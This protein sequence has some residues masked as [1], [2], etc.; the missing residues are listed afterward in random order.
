MTQGLVERLAAA[1]PGGEVLTDE[2]DR[3]FFATDVFRAGKMPLAV[4]APSTLA[5]LQEVVRLCGETRTP[6]AIRGGGASYTDG[7]TPGAPRGISLS[8]ARLNR[9]LEIDEEDRTVTVEPG[10]TW[11]ALDAALRPRGWRTPFFGPFSGLVSTVGGAVSQNAISHGTGAFGSAAE[12]LL[13]LEVVTGTGDLLATGS[14][15][16]AVADPFLRHYGPDLAGLFTGDCGALGVK[17]RLTFRLVRRQSAAAYASFR[18]ERFEA[19]HAAMHVISAEHPDDT[20]FAVDAEISAGQ[21]ARQARLENRLGILKSVLSDARGLK[22]GAGALMRLARA[23]LSDDL[24]VAPYAAHYVIEAASDAEAEA[25]LER[26]RAL[27]SAHGT[28]IPAAAANVTR[29]MPFQPLVS[30][31]G[32]HG[33]RWVPVHGLFP[34]SR[35]IGFHH[36]LKR[37]F[38]ERREIMETHGIRSGAMFMCVGPSA[39]LYEPTFVWPDART[40]YHARAMPAEWLARLPEL[41]ANPAAFEAVRALRAEVAELMDAHGA[42]HFQVGRF[43][44]YA[45]GRNPAALALLR[46][47]KTALD[48]HGILSPGALGL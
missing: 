37:L 8:T 5:E 3:R 15:G 20:H 47:V 35:V 40:I 30:M 18:F 31:L 34:H 14:A 16:S 22:E 25:R 12:S 43:Y 23:G 21:L 32:A 38:S 11:S 48:P 46:A 33:E 13:S 19:L 6:I 42:G 45:R 24:E 41:E 17:A 7:Y 1:T 10:V 2:A 29:A 27:A 26:L 9:I 39:F 4:V 36:A 44:G 28:E